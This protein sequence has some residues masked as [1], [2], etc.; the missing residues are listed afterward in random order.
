[1]KHPGWLVIGACV[2]SLAAPRIAAACG[3]GGVVMSRP[4]SVGANAQR[5]VL[6]VRGDGTTLTTVVTTQIAV[7]ATTNDYGAL[8][9]LPTEP[10]LYTDPIS[11]EELD[12]LDAATAPRILSESRDDDSGGGCGCG[13][14]AAG[15]D[16]GAVG[17][18]S[19]RASEPVDIGPVTAVVLSGTT[20]AVNTWLAD[21]GFVLSATD[22]AIVSEYAGYYFVAIRRNEKT[23]PGGPTSIGIHFAMD[24]DH[25]ELPLR[26]AR[27]G[28]AKSVAFTLFLITND[29]VGPSSPF[30]ALT[31][32]DLE[33]PS[34]Y[35]GTYRS[36]VE[37]AV[38]AHGYRAFVLESRTE[39][40]DAGTLSGWFTGNQYYL[41]RL[42]TVL[43][44]DQLTE[45]AHFYA[46]FDDD[47]P[48]ERRINSVGREASLGFLSLLL[49]L[50]GWRRRRPPATRAHV[51]RSTDSSSA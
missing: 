27:L 5:V 51:V 42:T 1:M 20:D 3:G 16:D 39:R 43:P 49:I 38:R 48:G 29:T 33:A 25:R 35:A 36:A 31:I 32:D 28:A 24:G 22:Q 23:A 45:D 4:G 34:L 37:S 44:V 6:S 14:G 13:L 19:V 21:N 30:A 18:R 12:A 15:A 40:L 8:L 7:P 10:H 26:F 9:P 41:T 17:A 46:T 50:G 2:W 11:V 47:V